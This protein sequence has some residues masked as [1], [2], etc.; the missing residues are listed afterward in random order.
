MVK[1]HGKCF[2]C[3]KKSINYFAVH[4]KWWHTK[5]GYVCI[6]CQPKYKVILNNLRIEFEVKK[7]D[8][9]EFIIKLKL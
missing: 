4:N 9:K 5:F 7:L 3:K 8:L 1:V 2:V 6:P